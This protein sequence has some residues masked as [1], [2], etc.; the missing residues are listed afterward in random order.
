MTQPANVVTQ[1]ANVVTQANASKSI[2]KLLRNN[3]IFIRFF[4][5]NA[6][7]LLCSNY[8]LLKEISKDTGLGVAIS[9]LLPS[10]IKDSEVI[11]IK[12]DGLIEDC[13]LVERPLLLQQIIDIM[14]NNEKYFVLYGASQ[15]LL[16]GLLKVGKASR[17]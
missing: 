8:A 10:K 3:F 6:V 7:A 16:R 14:K 12:Y 9:D 5:L 15:Q 4:L 17:F 1:P 13:L 2:L 11:T